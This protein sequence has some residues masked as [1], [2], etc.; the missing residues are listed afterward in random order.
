MPT[1]VTARNDS[2]QCAACTLRPNLTG[3]PLTK[4]GWRQDP[5][6]VYV[7]AA[8]FAQPAPRTY[9]DASVNF[10]TWPYTKNVD[11]TLTKSFN[12]HENVRFELRSDFF[13]LFNW[14]VFGSA[15]GGRVNMYAASDFQL[16]NRVLP[17]RTVQVSAR[18]AW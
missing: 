6:L 5:K 4:E 9:G 10:L 14:V 17:P 18:I 2:F 12:L 1:D 3:Q 7:N 15:P 16:Q 13:N 11:M 8:A